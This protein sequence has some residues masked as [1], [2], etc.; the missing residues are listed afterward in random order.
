MIASW[1]VKRMVRSVFDNAGVKAD[2][3]TAFANMADD[4]TYDVP[5]ELSEGVTVRSKKE[6]LDWFHRWYEQFPKRKLI[7][8]NIAFA[9]WP[10]CP[11]N[12]GIVEWTCEETDKAGREYRYDGATV[13]EMRNG[14][15][16]RTT[17]YIACK[18]LP[19]L[20]TLIKPVAKA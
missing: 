12:V 13:T 9:A 11:N 16:I 17:E 4:I 8:K 18:G 3:E 1:I 10:L 5:L 2:A 14:K 7:P 15:G 6:V 19:Q 20:S